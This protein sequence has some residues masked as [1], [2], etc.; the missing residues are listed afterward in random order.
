M[1]DEKTIRILRMA[2]LIAAQYA[3]DNLPVELNEEYIYC[4]VNGNADPC[5]ERFLNHWLKKAVD[6]EEEK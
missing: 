6:I 2:L 5:G 1:S 4:I 3:R